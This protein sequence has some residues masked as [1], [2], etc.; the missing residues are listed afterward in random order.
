MNRIRLATYLMALLLCLSAA[1]LGAQSK[2]VKNQ[3]NK[4]AKLEKEIQILDR[5]LKENASKSASATTTLNLTRKKIS[6]RKELLAQCEEQI[7]ELNSEI[8][9]T[10]SQINYLTLRLDTLRTNYEKL[11]LVAY[12]MR[13]SRQ[14]YMMLLTSDDLAQGYRRYA[15]MK[16]ISHELNTQGVKLRQLTD[17]LEVKKGELEVLKQKAQETKAQREREMKTLRKEESDASKQIASLQKDK[18]K[19]EKELALKRKQVDALKKEIEKLIAESLKDTK[20]SKSSGSGKKTSSKPKAPIDTKLDAEFAA[21]K[22]RLPW[23]AEGPV[24]DKYGRQFHPAFKSVELPFNDGISIAVDPGTDAYCVFDGVVK[25]I[26]VMPGYNQCVLVQHG[27]YFTFYCKLGVVYVKAGDKVKTGQ[28]IGSVDT[29]GGETLL[30]FEVWEG[31]RTQDP[32]NWLR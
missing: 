11:V 9:G 12:K 6:A 17:S 1:P 2:A 27:S 18:A 20:S 8:R 28:K 30:H 19:F 5:Q 14:W 16:N 15:Y 29:M 3:Q 22:G 7:K 25:N 21:N 31:T 13:D 26:I 10:D 4:K 32:A 24:V 23:P